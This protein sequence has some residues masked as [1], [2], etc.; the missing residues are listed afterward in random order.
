MRNMYSGM[1][2][3]A[4]SSFTTHWAAQRTV[5]LTGN[6]T[7]A[8]VVRALNP[9][10]QTTREYE[11]LIKIRLDQIRLDQISGLSISQGEINLTQSRIKLSLG[12]FLRY[13]SFILNL[14]APEE[15]SSL[16]CF[17]CHNSSAK[18]LRGIFSFS[19]SLYKYIYICICS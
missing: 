16:E 5:P 6:R 12:A 1:Y 2:P 15:L 17:I 4:Y 14:Y 19:L 13:K 11:D 10:H 9:D 8:T 18:L 7:Q 3:I